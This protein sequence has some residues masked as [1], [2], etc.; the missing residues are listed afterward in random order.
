MTDREAIV[1]LIYRY[2]RA[3]DR[4]DADLGY[5]VWHHDGTAD[6]GTNFSGRGHDFIDNVNAQHSGLIAH[7]HQVTNIIIEIDGDRA[8]SE[9]YCF[10]N[11]RMMRADVLMQISVWNRYIDRWS[12]RDGRWG[13]DHRVAIID[14]D[15]IRPVTGMGKAFE[16]KRDRS[17][18]SYAVLGSF[19]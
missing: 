1:D 12:R 6:Y 11:L 7:S 16:G 9:S 5:S 2:C 4:I 10:A 14:F 18:P 8:G 15:E 3:M 19:K 17:D 13:I